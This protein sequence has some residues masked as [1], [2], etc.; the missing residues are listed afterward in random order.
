MTGFVLMRVRAHRLLLAAALLTVVL[1][2]CVLATL[3]SYTGA[4]GDA[5]LRRTLQHQAADRSAFDVKASLSGEDRTALDRAVRDEL[6][7]AFGGLPAQVKAS[8]RSGPYGL[9]TAL[10]PAGAPKDSDPDLTLLATF[11]R[12]QLTLVGGSWPA[13]AA[14][15]ARTVQAAVPETVSRALHIAAGRQITLADRL[16]GPPLRIEITGVY[17]PT[18]PGSPYWQLDPLAGRGVHTLA[19][20]TYGPLLADP[21]TFDSGR[22]AA[23]EM[24]WQATGDFRK[25][26]AGRIDTLESAVEDTTARLKADKA[27]GA[28]QASTGLPDLLDGLRRSLLVT[29]STLLIG[30]FQLIILAA[31]ALLLVAQLLAEERAGETALLRARGGSRGR[32]ARLAAGEALLLALPAALV[33]PLLAGPVTHLL[34]GT[35]AMART[36]V[37]LDGG[38]AGSAWLVA[39]AA[40]LACALAVVVPALRST[41]STARTRRG[42]LPGAL[43]AG[44]DVALLVIAG[45]AYWQLQRRA[46]GSGALSSDK[47]GGLGIDPVLVAA[48]ALCL[49]AGTVL[50]LRLLPPAARL[51][52]RRAARGSGLALALAGW[53]LA[54]RPRRGAAAALL[55]VLA[56]AMGMFSIGQ[57]ASW[58]RSQRDQADFTVGADLRVTGMTTPPFGQAGIFTAVQGVTAAAPAARETL[59][60]PGDQHATALVMDTTKAASAMRIRS[61]LTDGRPLPALL[62]PLR[63]APDARG[64]AVDATARQVTFEATLT[65]QRGG[66]PAGADDQPDHISAAVVDAEGVSYDFA[67]GDLPPDGRP[68]TLTLD[69]ATA[70]G[71]GSP[72]GPLRLVRFESSYQVPAP[73]ESRRLALSSAQVTRADGTVEP[74]RMPAGRPWQTSA[75]FDDTSL[76]DVPGAVTPSATA[77]QAGGTALISLGYET[78]SFSLGTGSFQQSGGTLRVG[79]GTSSPA[80][81]TGIATDGYLRAAG[82]KV[83]DTVQVQLGNVTTPVVISSAVRALPGTDAAT[84]AGALLLDLRAVNRVLAA[85]DALPMQPTEWWLGT[86]PGAAGRAAAALRARTDVD[87]V[88]DRAAAAADLRADPLGAGPQSALPAAVIAA[89]VL[90]AVGFA[91]GAMGAARERRTEFAV[92][93]ALGAP[94]RKLTR[95]LAAEQGLL[96]VVSLAVGLALG[97]FLTRLITPLIILTGQATRPVP[98]LVIELPVGRLAEL[99]AVLLAAP[100]LVLVVTA[101]RRGEPAAALR[102]QA[103][104]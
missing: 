30:A 46:S 38:S 53:Q 71:K 63:T 23:D 37:T 7:R 39:G 78:G 33:A 90:A 58:D 27:T 12:A 24:S 72:A 62:A 11:D 49:L 56:V 69:L 92:L 100:L 88:L 35:G 95:M 87:T 83:G 68:H 101:V 1:T 74:L 91:V 17:R 25:A 76:G 102:H 20:T 9:P 104:D 82:A 86:R 32:V 10:R 80:R 19:F 40:A 103:E 29:R 36:G 85:G 50:V 51:G 18:D 16:G 77:A 79:A 22:V 45:V 70:A 26:S 65:A 81:L 96:V 41:G 97:T 98:P 84:E 2:T 43:Q 47:S 44:A 31:F 67:L 61:D 59:L 15:G 6:D 5:A 21:G 75:G 52:E 60:L 55:L 13:A 8:T 3:A 54:R 93:R 66:K 42:G 57:G 89:A 73:S 28:A 64:L 48:P 99:L 4:I 34:A 14:K 94:R